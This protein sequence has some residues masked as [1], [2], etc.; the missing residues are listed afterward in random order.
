M[1]VQHQFIEEQHKAA[2]ESTI[3]QHA[4]ITEPFLAKLYKAAFD[5]YTQAE[6]APPTPGLVFSR[7]VNEKH[8]VAS[9]TDERTGLYLQLAGE[10]KKPHMGKQLTFGQKWI[11][12]GSAASTTATKLW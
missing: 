5:V 3:R 2:L 8:V 6:L 7:F 4:G 11:M 9:V 1:F 12:Q 10:I